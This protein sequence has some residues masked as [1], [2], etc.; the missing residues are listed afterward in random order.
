MVTSIIYSNY[1]Y[2]GLMGV[3]RDF[4]KQG[5]G[6]ALMEHLLG[7]LDRQGIHQVKLDASPFGQPLYEKLGFVPLD[8]V[9]VLQRQI[10]QPTYQRPAEVQIL[11]PRN[12]GSITA[13]D[14]PVF[15]ADRSRLLQAL[16]E[17]YPERAFLLTDRRGSLTGYLIAQEKRIGPWVMEN[18]EDSESLLKATLSLP[19]AGTVSVATPAN[20]AGAVSLLQRY[21]F[22]IIRVNRHMAYGSYEV[23]GQREKVYGQTSLSFG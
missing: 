7:W 11:S 18:T 2:V 21:G 8:E 13:T 16:L 4:Q 3:H 14:T 15:G 23:I 12:L 1:A 22:Q 9:Y 6:Q 5:I 10:G 19:F 20:N 17:I